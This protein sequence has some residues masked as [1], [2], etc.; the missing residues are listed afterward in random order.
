MVQI[1]KF[2]VVNVCKKH[3]CVS[4]FL[5]DQAAC[6]NV[7]FTM[8]I[9]CELNFCCLHDYEQFPIYRVYQTSLYVLRCWS[10]LLGTEFWDDE[11]TL[12]VIVDE[13]YFSED[14]DEEPVA[15]A[16]EQVH[17]VRPDTILRA[18]SLETY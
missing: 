15:I 8:R 10:T 6:D 18:L 5:W 2:C 9:F 1:G 17:T 7:S 16:T 3:F 4:R 13:K 14:R 12:Q 11:K